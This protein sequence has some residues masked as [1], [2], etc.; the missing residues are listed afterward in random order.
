MGSNIKQRVAKRKEKS[1]TEKRNKQK[2]NEQYRKKE[3]KIK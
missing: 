1:S 3:A 2:V